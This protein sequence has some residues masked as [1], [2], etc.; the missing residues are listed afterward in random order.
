MPGE[1]TSDAGLTAQEEMRRSMRQVLDHI[2]VEISYRFSQLR[3][4]ESRFGFLIML[5][6]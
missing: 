4:L 2:T 3:E 5:N 6:R 1:N